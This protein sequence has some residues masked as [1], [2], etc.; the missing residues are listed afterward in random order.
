MGPA[1]SFGWTVK[2]R[3]LRRECDTGRPCARARPSLVEQR[4]V[5]PLTMTGGQFDCVRCGGKNALGA[6]ACTDCRWPFTL[7]AWADFGRPPYRITLDTGCINARRQNEELNALELWAQ[8]GKVVLQRSEA[9]LAEIRGEERVSK[10]TA[11]TP[12]PWLFTLGVS[13]LNGPDV[14]AGPDMDAEVE[15]VLF[16]TS[17]TLTP[18]QRHDVEHLRRHIQ[19]GGDVFVTLN[20]NDFIARGRQKRFRSVGIW[21]MSPGELVSLLESTLGWR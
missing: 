16:P 15:A 7:E 13:A 11:L 4:V 3:C 9:M 20:P 17:A 5:S 6:I 12:H 2:G 8:Q 14:L 1:S 19:T 21:V 18:N 10:A